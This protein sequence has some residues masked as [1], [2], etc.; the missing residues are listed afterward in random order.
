MDLNRLILK[1]ALFSLRLKVTSGILT[2]WSRQDFPF[3]DS[4]LVN[5]ESNLCI[6]SS[7]VFSTGFS[8]GSMYTNCLAQ[9][10]QKVSRD[11]AVYETAGYNIYIPDNTGEPLAWMDV[12]GMSDGLCPLK[13]VSG[14]HISNH[15]NNGQSTFNL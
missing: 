13:P 1:A 8:Y 10:H 12:V 7:R 15:T 9:N 14:S 11:V 2:P 4:L 5:L 6:G 3:F